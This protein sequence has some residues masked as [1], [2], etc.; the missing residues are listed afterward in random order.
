[1]EDIQ[2]HT[3][4]DNFQKPECPHYDNGIMKD[5]YLIKEDAANYSGNLP[6]RVDNE[7]C[8]ECYEFSPIT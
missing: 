6:D 4:C 8:K 5:L 3:D 1:M 7:L 2:K